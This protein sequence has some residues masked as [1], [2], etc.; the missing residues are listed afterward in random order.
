MA[1]FSHNFRKFSV[2]YFRLKRSHH[3]IRGARRC[4]SANWWPNSRAVAG[5]IRWH[6]RRLAVDSLTY[7]TIQVSASLTLIRFVILMFC[8]LLWFS[9]IDLTT[10]KINNRILNYDNCFYM[11]TTL[12]VVPFSIVFFRMRRHRNDYRLQTCR[13]RRFAGSQ[14]T[15]SWLRWVIFYQLLLTLMNKRFW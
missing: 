1:I 11:Y 13:L 7:R 3:R 15:A 12:F 6:S 8:F 2:T 14:R 9:V 5:F 4:R 10:I